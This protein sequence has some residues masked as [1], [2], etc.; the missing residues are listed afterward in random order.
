MDRARKHMKVCIYSLLPKYIYI[1]THILHMH[2]VISIYLFLF[3]SQY[4]LYTH[5][6]T[7]N[8]CMMNHDTPNMDT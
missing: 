5:T 1:H 4:V 2:I 8:G 6:H 7:I 3:L